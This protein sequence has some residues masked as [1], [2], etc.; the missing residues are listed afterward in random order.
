MQFKS[1]DA[2]QAAQLRVFR[3]DVAGDVS[4]VKRFVDTEAAT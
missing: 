4:F 2:R 3:P 1:R